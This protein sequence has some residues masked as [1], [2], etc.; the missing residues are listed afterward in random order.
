MATVKW[1]GR[2]LVVFCITLSSGCFSF[3]LLSKDLPSVPSEGDPKLTVRVTTVDGEEISLKK[4]WVDRWVLGGEETKAIGA[5][6]QIKIPHS[7]ID[8][9]EELEFDGRRTLQNVLVIFG[10]LGAGAWCGFGRC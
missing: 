9:V 1:I 7:R 10:V 2:P 5:P 4:P 8:L 3:S 6:R